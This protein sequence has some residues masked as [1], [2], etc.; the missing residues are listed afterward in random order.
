MPVA[1]GA[2]RGDE[3][4]ASELPALLARLARLWAF[5]EEMDDGGLAKDD[6]T[7]LGARVHYRRALNAAV[8]LVRARF[9]GQ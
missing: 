7:A 2:T 1:E 3:L 4:P 5:A 8:A 9:S 6:V